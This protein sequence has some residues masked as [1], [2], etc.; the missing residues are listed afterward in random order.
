MKSSWTSLL[1]EPPRKASSTSVPRTKTKT[2]VADLIY[3][4]KTT[5]LSSDET[6][7]LN[8]YLHVE[9]LMR[10]AKAR[11][12]SYLQRDN[13]RVSYL[14]QCRVATTRDGTRGT[15]LRVLPNRRGRHFLW[16]RGRPHYQR[17]AWRTYEWGQSG[18]R[19][20]V[21]QSSKG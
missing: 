1:G 11:T 3:R 4:Q 13:N 9:H 10:L 20:R 18:I 17:E 5:S 21:L 12:A 7:E 2:R 15:T 19:L 6:A 14:Y 16:L 8:Q